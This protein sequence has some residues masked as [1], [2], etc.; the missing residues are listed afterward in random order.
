MPPVDVFQLAGYVGWDAWDL[1]VYVQA[2]DEIGGF[3][4]ISLKVGRRTTMRNIVEISLRVAFQT[5]PLLFGEHLRPDVDFATSEGG[6]DDII[7]DSRF[8][9]ADLEQLALTRMFC[10]S[11]VVV[12][13]PACFDE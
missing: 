11:S 6:A 12:L 13:I 9:S 3:T 7:P 8:Y 4:A 5:R 1:Q 10:Y 2:F